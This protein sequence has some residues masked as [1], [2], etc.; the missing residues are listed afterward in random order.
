MFG[1]PSN[2]NM[3]R[4][5]KAGNIGPPKLQMPQSGG[6]P[7]SRMH[8]GL[9]KSSLGA[10]LKPLPSFPQHSMRGTASS[11][12]QTQTKKPPTSGVGL[13]LLAPKENRETNF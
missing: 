9:R 12:I 2:A 1:A 8:S 6:D 13:D 5:T 3:P 4:P 10:S 7:Q 11:L